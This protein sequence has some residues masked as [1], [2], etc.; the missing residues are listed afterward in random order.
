MDATADRT[1]G[2]QYSQPW[3]NKKTLIVTTA[4]DD[5][6]KSTFEERTVEILTNTHDQESLRHDNLDLK[7]FHFF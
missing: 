4:D 5:P 1:I 7:K 2:Q 3:V 6:G